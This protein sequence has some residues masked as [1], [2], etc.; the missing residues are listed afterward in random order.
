[1]SC[2]R[3]K[4][5]WASQIKEREALLAIVLDSLKCYFI[6]IVKPDQVWLIDIL[7]YFC[8]QDGNQKTCRKYRRVELKKLNP[9]NIIPSGIEPRA[10]CS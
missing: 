4:G 7:F 8:S 1:M 9:C 2:Q 5:D 10:I 3:A 6:W